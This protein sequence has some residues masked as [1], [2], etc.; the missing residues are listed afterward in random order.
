[1]WIFTNK[2]FISI[3]QHR[4]DPKTFLVRARRAEHLRNLFPNSEILILDDAD[5]RYRVVIP[6]DVAVRRISEL[7]DNIDYPNFKS[8]IP[9]DDRPY[10]DLCHSVW[11]DAYGFQRRTENDAH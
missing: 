9:A 4:D 2:G 5:Y 7:V 3:V 1:M 10:Q 11:Y 8:S 6:R